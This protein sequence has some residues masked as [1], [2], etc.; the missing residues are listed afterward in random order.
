MTTPLAEYRFLSWVRRGIAAELAAPAAATLPA[1]ATVQ[2]EINLQGTPVPGASGT[3]ALQVTAAAALY[4]P[5]DVVGIDRH[6]VVRTEPTDG[7]ANFEPDYFAG[8]EFD[9]PDFPWLFTPA[10][11]TSNR[12]PPWVVLIALAASEFD[13]MKEPPGPL[14]AINIHDITTLPDLSE[15]WAWAHG[16][17]AVDVKDQTLDVAGLLRTHP[18]LAASRILCPRHLTPETAY[19]AFLVPAYDVGKFAGL[20]QQTSSGAT[21]NRSWTAQ[22]PVPLQLPVYYQFS[23]HTSDQGDFESLVRRM[24]QRILPG[25]VG[26]RP[27]DVARIRSGPT[28]QIRGATPSKL[29]WRH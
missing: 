28:T 10:G 25:S 17:L 6:H 29:S 18:E 22:T 11:A 13:P 1:R 14:P 20:G 8:L 16:Q 19:T 15:S 21:L 26:I 24:Q 3:T 7:T 9:Q 27:M 4:G 5:G 12:L 23:F 2:T